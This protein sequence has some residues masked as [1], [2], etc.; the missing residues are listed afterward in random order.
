MRILIVAK[1]KESGSVL[2]GLLEREADLEVVGVVDVDND[3][4]LAAQ[5]K[6]IHPDV[7]LVDWEP[8][9]PPVAEL[10]SVLEESG[11]SPQVLVLG[12]QSGQQ[13]EA[14]LAEGADAFVS[15][16]DPP[17]RLL[18]A[19]RILDLERQYGQ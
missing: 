19:L 1:P 10:L 4:E 17:K 5:V 2:A 9:S 18:T 11:V 7:V 3:L 8:S 6:A 16:G 15:K 13:R 14:V 12:T